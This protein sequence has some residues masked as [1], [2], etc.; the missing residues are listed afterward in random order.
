MH[1]VGLVILAFGTGLSKAL[2]LGRLRATN[3]LRKERHPTP[4]A[5]LGAGTCHVSPFD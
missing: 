2:R 3:A 1:T 5:R 4:F